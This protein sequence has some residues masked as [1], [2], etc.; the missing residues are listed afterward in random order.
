MGRAV[1]ASTAKLAE[2]GLKA[3]IKQTSFVLFVAGCLMAAVG[4]TQWAGSE[5]PETGQTKVIAEWN[6]D[7]ADDLQGWQPNAQI[8]DQSSQ[9]GSVL[10]NRRRRPN[11]FPSRSF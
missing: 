8:M 5:Q 10:P 3:M 2:R 11:P 7:K 6:F 1:R 4:L 9:R